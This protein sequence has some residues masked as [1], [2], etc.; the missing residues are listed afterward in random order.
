MDRWNRLCR[1]VNQSNVFGY[2]VNQFGSISS[3]HKNYRVATEEL[4][5]NLSMDSGDFSQPSMLQWMWATEF[6]TGEVE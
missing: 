3:G 2:F 4:S 1:S 5:G 6:S